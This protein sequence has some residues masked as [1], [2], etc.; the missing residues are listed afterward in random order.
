GGE[1]YRALKA[2]AAPEHIVF[3]GVGKTDRELDEGLAAGIGWFNVESADELARLNA[4]AAARG[5]RARV[6]LRLNPNV[7]PDT[8]KHIQ[9]G[10]VANKFGLPL[11]AALALAGRMADYPAIELRGVHIHIGSQVPDAAPT[12]QALEA[13][14]EFA[15]QVPGIDTLDL[16]GGFPVAY[17]ADDHYAGVEAFATPIVERLRDRGLRVH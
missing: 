17:R 9:T 5:Q 14:L 16:G 12:L 2:R 7:S 8:H 4:R 15:G 3:A 11:P 13:A 10:G 6:A 1:L